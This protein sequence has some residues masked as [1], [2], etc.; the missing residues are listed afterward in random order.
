TFLSPDQ[1]AIETNMVLFLE[2]EVVYL[3]K[4]F[5]S[6]IINLYKHGKNYELELLMS[7][8]SPNEYLRRNEYLQ[9]FAQSRK[10]DLIDLKSKRQI[11]EEKKKML[12]LS[13]SSQRFY[14]EGK[15]HDKAILLNKMNELISLKSQFEFETLKDKTKIEKREQMIN[16]IRSFIDNFTSNQKNYKGNKTIRQSYS[17][18]NFDAIKGNMNLPVDIGIVTSEFGD[19]THNGTG[20]KTYNTGIDLSIVKGSKV[21]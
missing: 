2:E 11:L 1:V 21:Y 7:A 6:R 10:K 5:R 19:G 15:R 20:T 13:T 14:V 12:T 16:G 18:E 8:K 17:S 4:S 3:Q 9:K